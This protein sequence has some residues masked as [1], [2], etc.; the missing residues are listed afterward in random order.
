MYVRLQI[1]DGKI[2]DLLVAFVQAHPSVNHWLCG[3]V[4][5]ELRPGDPDGS[6]LPHLPLM[7]G[8]H[9]TARVTDPTAPDAVREVR[10]DRATIEAGLHA[11]MGQ[12]AQGKKPVP[13]RHYA[14]W[15][16]GSADEVTADAF[17]QCCV[18]GELV[19]G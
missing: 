16:D 13:V 1:P 19:Y 14:R 18:F 12:P 2:R 3:E 10:L 4:P 5:D 11:F 7:E 9:V 6:P 15:M 8:R 17:V